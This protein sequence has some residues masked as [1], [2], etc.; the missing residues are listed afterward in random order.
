M[1][2]E[3]LM[4]IGMGLILVAFGTF[5]F[6]KSE[7][8]NVTMFNLFSDDNMCVDLVSSIRAQVYSFSE[9]LSLV[10]GGISRINCGVS[11]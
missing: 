8:K 5:A 10:C 11:I 4:K 7:N 9:K 2:F 3:K 6:G 1:Y